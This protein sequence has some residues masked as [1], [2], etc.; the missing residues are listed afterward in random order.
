MMCQA[1][2]KAESTVTLK[3]VIAGH[4]DELALCARCA[5]ELGAAIAPELILQHVAQPAPLDAPDTLGTAK[6]RP[7]KSKRARPVLT[8]KSCGSTLAQLKETGRLGCAED[9]KVFATAITRL[10]LTVQGATEHR[11]RQ[12][13]RVAARQA[14]ERRV[15]ALK[16]ELDLAIFKEDYERAATL[17]DMLQCLEDGGAASA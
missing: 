15:A 1:C 14:H 10:L 7:S 12:P 9:Y 3:Q 2:Q 5:A 11:G 8:C 13:A 17:R 6:K 4:K 16:I